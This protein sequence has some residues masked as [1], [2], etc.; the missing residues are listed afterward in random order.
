MADL[1]NE[2]QLE[3]DIGRLLSQQPQRRAP[4][5]LEDRV[6]R[7]LTLRA[8]KPWWLQGYSR[9]PWAARAMFLPLGIA[10]VQLSFVTTGRLLALWQALQSS[11]PASS[12]Q[13]GL[14]LLANLT[15]TVQTLGS[16]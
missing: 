4:A 5:T 14:S 10:L 11:A 12:A 3:R 2:Q 8:S 7:E 6:L 13:S 16:I 15:Q 1:N 9:W